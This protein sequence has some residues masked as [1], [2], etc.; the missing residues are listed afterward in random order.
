[1][2][3]ARYQTRE[4]AAQ[5][6]IFLKALSLG[7]TAKNAAAE[8][9]V[10]L[11]T[12]Y[13]MRR[14]DP[15]LAARWQAALATPDD[16]PTDVLELEAQ[17][18]AVTGTEKPVFRGGAIV[19]HTTDYSDA[20]LMFLLKAKYP[21]KYDRTKAANTKAANIKTD[22]DAD[23]AGTDSTAGARDALLSKF[24]QATQ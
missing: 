20:M 22:A 10:G 14:A 2:P 23:S 13:R 24:A 3:A 17:R 21:E 1:M 11:R 7:S 15:L 19:G 12:L 4:R 5:L 18:R 9:G 8:A 6:A 16:A